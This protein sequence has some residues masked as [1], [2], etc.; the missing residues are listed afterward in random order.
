[1]GGHV[2]VVRDAAEGLGVLG[3]V[4]VL[5]PESVAAAGNC[6][7]LRGLLGIGPASVQD[8]EEPFWRRLWDFGSRTQG[9][10]AVWLGEKRNT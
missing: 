8:G 1:V 4:V 9:L 3:H 5:V 7:L 2:L 6:H 10:L